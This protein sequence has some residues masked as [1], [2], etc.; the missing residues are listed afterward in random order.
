MKKIMLSLAFVLLTCALS[1]AADFD[2]YVYWVYPGTRRTIVWDP[3]AGGADKYEVAI[4]RMN[5]G[6]N[7][8]QGFVTEPKITVLF[9]SAGLDVVYI[10]AIKG[11]EI[12]EWQNTLSP[13]T[14]T[15]NGQSKP[16][17]IL[18]PTS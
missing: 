14:S 9:R 15:V 7:I 5:S 11:A 18:V 12:G 8:Y 16:W 4:Y 13:G 2:A 10:R 1:Q 17:A 6:R 3:P